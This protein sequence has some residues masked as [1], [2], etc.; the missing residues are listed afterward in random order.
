MA[1]AAA[2]H[3]HL[4]SSAATPPEPAA[5]AHDAV[6]ALLRRLLDRGI[7]AAAI[8]AHTGIDVACLDDPDARVPLPRFN[9]LWRYA[10][11]VLGEPALALDLHEHY[12][13][14][15]MHF[16][17][18]LG[19]RCASLRQA[20]AQ[21]RKYA[22]LVSETDAVDCE[23]DGRRARFIYRCLDPR[24]A[25]R[26]MAEHYLAVALFYA[27]TFSGQPLQIDAVSL[28]HE[29]PGYADAYRRVFGCTPVFGARDNA[30]VFDA[31]L[32][33][34]P[35]RSADPYL[36]HFLEAR[37]DELMAQL[38]PEPSAARQ[39]QQALA[40]L[41]SKGQPLTLESAAQ[42]LTLPPR[43][44]R[45]MLDAE[46]VG[47]RELLNEF[48]RDAA[49]Q[50]LRQGLTVSQTAYLLGFSEPAAFQHAFRRWFGQSAGQFQSE[51]RTSPTRR[52]ASASPRKP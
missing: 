1:K 21:W 34:V 39:V 30:L 42:T 44:L 17:A 19:M 40:L 7:A 32:L 41:L 27:R 2:A 12:P 31:A 38:A 20:I 6:Y 24:H 9:A 22:L 43:R 14:N 37:A 51:L 45:L 3:L 4:V 18:H 29:D 47:F 33:D 28:M 8:T 48:R 26:W 5:T 11:S 50:Y 36:R 46:G 49:A 16:V 23:V 35:F 15:R 25:S 52:M 10:S 13:D